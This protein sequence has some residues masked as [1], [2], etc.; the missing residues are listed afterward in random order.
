MD[1][2]VLMRFGVNDQA[3]PSQVHLSDGSILRPVVT[4]SGKYPPAKPGA[5]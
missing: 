2:I 1:N 3:G 4:T 5:L